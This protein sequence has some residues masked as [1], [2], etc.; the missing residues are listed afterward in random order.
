MKFNIKSESYNLIILSNYIEAMLLTLRTESEI[1]INGIAS[2]PTRITKFTVNRSPHIDK[3][4]R[5]QFEIRIYSKV[6]SINGPFKN[7]MSQI[8]KM[9]LPEGMFIAIEIIN[10]LPYNKVYINGNKHIVN[11]N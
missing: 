4:S 2:L 11:N 3:K 5:D 8:L 10:T 7:I 1:E 6:L 9:H